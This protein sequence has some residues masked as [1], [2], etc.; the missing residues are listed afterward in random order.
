MP[1]VPIEEEVEV[2][3]LLGF[4]QNQEEPANQQLGG[5]EEQQEVL[6]PSNLVG[7][8]NE[9][10]SEDQSEDQAEQMEENV[11]ENPVERLNNMESLTTEAETG[12]SL[13]AAIIEVEDVRAM[14]TE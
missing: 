5:N 1:G 2:P 4:V 6:S 12:A 11:Q 14:M 10:G 3:I 13:D 9:T 8:G 7:G